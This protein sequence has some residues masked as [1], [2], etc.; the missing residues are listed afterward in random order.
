[1]T[2]EAFIERKSQLGGQH[3][4]DPVWMPDV[5]FDFQKHLVEWATR[6]GR[7]ATYAD[8]GLGKTLLQLVW[9]ENVARQTNKR[10]LILT[11][12]AVSYQT[13]KEAEKF[14]IE[15][16]RARDGKFGAKAKIVVTNYHQ[17]HK[18]D[19]SDFEAVVCDEASAIKSADGKTTAQVTEF[20]RTIPY[21]YLC[22]ATPAPN[23]FH[24]LGTSSEALGGLGY[25]DMLGRFFKQETGKD[26]RGWGRSKY[27]LIGHAEEP[28]WKWVCSW[29]RACRKPSDIGFQDGDFVLPELEETEINLECNKPRPGQLFITPP[30]TMADH[31]Y[32]R[33]NTITERCERAA[34]EVDGHD[35]HSLV[36]CHLNPEADA[37]EKMVPDA[38][39]VSGSMSDEQKEERLLAFSAG[40]LKCLVLKPKIGCWGL[41]WQHCHHQVMFPSDSFE[42]YY[43]AVRRS[44]RFGQK[45]KVT[46]KIITTEGGRGVLDNL[47]RKSARA[48]QMFNL[49][50]KFMGEA[51]I[52]ERTQY[53]SME[54]MLPEWL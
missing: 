28:F 6:S 42:Q 40:D 8:C 43:Q 53:G 50:T 31:Q 14:G 19:S 27:R 20:M 35:G 37:V 13:L 23:D 39:Q 25:R 16:E 48:D 49:L 5:L 47:K 52:H 36:W 38:L 44:W 18:F 12:L 4:F 34:E 17:L 30:K 32:E 22:T 9:A 45:N 10:T 41:N 54:R 1:M 24:E 29:A 3:G 46:I 51:V 7:S 15:V 26:H 21:R 11:P 2:Y 33:R